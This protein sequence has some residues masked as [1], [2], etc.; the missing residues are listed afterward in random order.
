MGWIM[1]VKITKRQKILE[2]N[3]DMC[4]N[5]YYLVHGRFYN[6]DHSTYRKFQFVLW[7]DIFDV[8]EYFNYID[9]DDGSEWIDRPITTDMIDEYYKE[10]IWSTV[11]VVSD[12]NN[13]K[14]LRYFYD[15][16]DDSI[17]RYNEIAKHW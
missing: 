8:D 1:E 12:Y 10:I 13:E 6:E 2:I 9:F 4:H 11:S 5:Y 16:C 7:F 17:I 14:Q 15:W 3:N